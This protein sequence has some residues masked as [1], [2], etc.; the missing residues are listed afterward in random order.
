MYKRHTLIARSNARYGRPVFL[1]VN[2]DGKRLS[3]TGVEGP[4]GSG[5]CSG[6]CGQ[7]ILS[8]RGARADY[9]PENGIDLDKVLEIW[10]RWHLNDMI[11]GS[12]A[13]MEFLRQNPVPREGYAATCERLAEVGLN[14]DPAADGY[15]YG[16][17]WLREDVPAEVIEFLQSLPDD[18]GKLPSVWR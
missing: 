17:K 16:T 18:G 5:N 10:D 14:P 9:I 7:I 12:P 4:Y 11:A 1:T 13:Q 2:W 15:K 6:S 3:M 8:M